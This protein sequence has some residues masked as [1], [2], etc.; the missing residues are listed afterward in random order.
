MASSVTLSSTS[1]VSIIGCGLTR[2][3]RIE[4]ASSIVI[5]LIRVAAKYMNQEAEVTI[6]LKTADEDTKFD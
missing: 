6:I 4:V 1:P 2:R 5:Y 3:T